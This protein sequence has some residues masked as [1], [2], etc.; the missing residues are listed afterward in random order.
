MLVKTTLRKLSNVKVSHVSLVERG[1][2]RIPFRIIK[3][4]KPEGLDLSTRFKQDGK[5]D[6]A[7]PVVV[8]VI[9]FDRG[10]T[11]MP[12]VNAA[13]EGAGFSTARA[14]K[15]EDGTVY[16]EQ[17]P[18]ADGEETH[19][20]RLS[21]QM[22]VV[23]KGLAGYSPD[24]SEASFNDKVQAQGYFE[25]IRTCTNVFSQTLMSLMYDN[26][27]SNVTKA[28]DQVKSLI[29]DFGNYVMALTSALPQSVFKADESLCAL[30]G[31]PDALEEE[32]QTETQNPKVEITVDKSTQTEVVK[33]DAANDAI[34]A[35]AEQDAATARG[36]AEIV[37]ATL[38]PVL[39]PMTAAMGA[40]TESLKAISMK[41]DSM[42]TELKAATAKAEKA[43]QA[44][45]T[46][47]TARAQSDLTKPATV[48]AK[49][50]DTH[51]ELFD[52]AYGA[53][54]R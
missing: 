36:I 50:E 29:E 48:V 33:S 46:T 49:G 21:D 34:A 1:A 2:N 9:T 4:Q 39:A 24:L 30:A 3:S 35:K 28:E 13:L 27:T 51:V 15:E 37:K 5:P 20:I 19:L 41:Q 53:R 38:E 10:D 43:E 42:D 6:A 54:R 26:D 45:T 18:V 44:V 8:G 16:F 40:I 7:P 25:G 17:A 52:T 11:L 22:A 23:V 31:E 47:T 32:P 14:K 12:K